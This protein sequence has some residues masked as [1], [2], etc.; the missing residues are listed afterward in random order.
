[1]P[2]QL[3]RTFLVT[4]LLIATQAVLLAQSNSDLSTMISL[5]DREKLSTVAEA[6]ELREKNQSNAQQ[7]AIYDFS[8]ALV[9]MK[10]GKWQ[11]AIDVLQPFVE[12][13]PQVYRARLMLVRA[14]IELERF[15]A[16][17]VEFEAMLEKL[18]TDVETLEELAKKLGVF[19][20]FLK[21]CRE[22][23]GLE[24]LGKKLEAAAEAKLP[25]SAKARFQDGVRIVVNTVDKLNADME[26]LTEKVE[27]ETESKIES[28][29]LE[30]ERLKSEAEAKQAELQAIEKD[31][32]EKLEKVKSELA[33]L[34]LASTNL[35]AR[36]NLLDNQILTMQQR[37]QSLVQTVT[38]RDA[39]GNT[40]T[41]EQITN[42]AE[43]NRLGRMIAN[44]SAELLNNQAQA[45]QLA[46]SYRQLQTQAAG[47]AS[48][49]ELDAMFT[50]SK[51]NELN[52][53]A[54][55]KQKRA[56]RDADRKGKLA[57]SAAKGI[58]VKLKTYGT[59]ESLNL[60]VDKAYLTGIAKK[61]LN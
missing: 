27:E 7:A 56:E 54:E 4:C 23:A 33:K 43:Y 61:F 29:L 20:A 13:R 9:L 57:A 45:R 6:K 46:A 5:L 8:Y 40:R 36:Q 14:N 41:T 49:K 48:K 55:S 30:A 28:N 19:S 17:A 10:F 52:K 59:Y 60:A 47:M 11:D 44:S 38:E 3:K 18:P 24:D 22:D 1:M 25:E 34:E 58:Q 31:R 50:K 26:R 12:K 42:P 32:I 35:L 51:M 21:L 16:A 37:Q 15:E 39:N 2:Q 53:A